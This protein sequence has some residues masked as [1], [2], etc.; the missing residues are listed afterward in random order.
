MVWCISNT[1][2]CCGNQLSLSTHFSFKKKKST[3]RTEMNVLSIKPG[4][5]FWKMNGTVE[6]V[7]KLLTIILFFFPLPQPQILQPSQPSASN[8][9]KLA[10]PSHPALSEALSDRVDSQPGDGPVKPQSC[11]VVLPVSATSNAMLPSSVPTTAPAVS[12]AAASLSSSTLNSDNLLLLLNTHLRIDESDSPRAH[13]GNY[14]QLRRTNQQLGDPHTFSRDR[15][16]PVLMKP[17][18]GEQVGL[19]RGVRSAFGAHRGLSG[20]SRTRHLP[21]PSRGLP[22]ISSASQ[23]NLI[24]STHSSGIRKISAPRNEET[25]SVRVQDPSN[26][27]NSRL[28]KPKSH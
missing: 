21:P 8:H 5:F 4:V 1:I 9:N 26:A 7:R 15:K 12:A 27:C 18:G 22:C 2:G 17:R 28:P 16:A 6:P 10:R 20:P 3:N 11:T 13:V 25:G 14:V 23:S 24:P 19:G